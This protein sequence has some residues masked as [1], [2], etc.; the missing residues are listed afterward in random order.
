MKK[1]TKP[2]KLSLLA[3]S[4]LAEDPATAGPERDLCQECGLFQNSKE[5]YQTMKEDPKVL[6]LVDNTSP[7]KE[8][9]NLL[10]KELEAAGVL[11][12]DYAWAFAVRCAPDDDSTP[13]MKQIRCCRPF[14]LWALDR[15][16]PRV[17]LALGVLAAKALLNSGDVSIAG[18]RG[19]PL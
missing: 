10:R 15:I 13:N 1:P 4:E 18:S 19:R 8:V 9:V 3:R 11:P 17:R 12:K 2:K 6:A 16:Q 14:L 7:K 5:P